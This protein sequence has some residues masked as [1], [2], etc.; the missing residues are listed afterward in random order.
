VS[1]PLARLY[2]LGLRALDDQERRADAL[3][4]RLGPVLAAAALGVTLL[5]GPLV[6]NAHPATVVGTLA[7]VVAVIGLALTVG[8]AFR[9][10][11]TRHRPAAR[12]DARKLLDELAKE[13]ALDD[14]AGFYAAM[15]TRLDNAQKRN[16]DASER[17]TTDLQAMMCGIIV[18]LCGLALVALIG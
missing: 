1:E 3:R 12:L 5:S 15:I 13:G 8:A 7:L 11:Y 6:G 10:L 16:A 17:L 14:V 9:V 4:S 18:M 2:D